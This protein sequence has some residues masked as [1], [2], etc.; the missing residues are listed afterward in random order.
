MGFFSK[1]GGTLALEQTA[2]N[3]HRVAPSKN[4]TIKPITSIGRAS[5]SPCLFSIDTKKT[6]SSFLQRQ[7][8]P[9]FSF[10]MVKPPKAS[11]F[12]RASSEVILLH[13]SQADIDR[14]SYKQEPKAGL[15]G[16]QKFQRKVSFA[17]FCESD[18]GTRR[19][20]E[21]D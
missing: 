17:I 19:Q 8:E 20:E 3:L 14:P 2:P 4:S 13:I 11:R 12:W 15:A 6:T 7:T 16:N 1:R 9:P 21:G 5:K 10:K 18:G